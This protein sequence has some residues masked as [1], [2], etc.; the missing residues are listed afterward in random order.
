MAY[1]KQITPFFQL[2]DKRLNRKIEKSSAKQS[3]LGNFSRALLG[4]PRRRKQYLVVAVDVLLCGISAFLAFFI[5]LEIDSIYHTAV[6]KVFAISAVG[7]IPILW[8]MGQYQTAFR[9]GGLSDNKLILRAAVTYGVYFVLAIAILGLENVP[10]SVGIIQPTILFI[11]VFSIR[12]L[13]REFMENVN[14]RFAKNPKS[15]RILIYGAGITGRQLAVVSMRS[16]DWKFCGFL[17]DDRTLWGATIDGQ[18]VYNPIDCHKV[19]EK[20]SVDEIWIA[21]PNLSADRRRVI[22]EKL[23]P[24]TAHVKTLPSFFDI[25]SRKNVLSEV[26]ELNFNDFLGRETVTPNMNLI[27]NGIKDRTILVTGAG[28]SIGAELCRL[29]LDSNP[30]RLIILDQS[31]YALYLIHRELVDNLA[32]DASRIDTAE[33]NPKQI[34]G[35][36]P[37]IVPILA[38]CTNESLLEAI[39][40]RWMPET[41]FHAAAFKHVPLVESNIVS[42]VF[43]NVIGTYVCAKLAT[44]YDARTFILIST[45]KAVRPTN[46]MGV[47]KRLSE[48]VIKYFS[49]TSTRQHCLFSAVRFGN[50]LG[51][52]GSVIP[53]FQK[54]IDDGGPVTITHSE[55]TRYFMTIREAAELVLQAAGIAKGGEI[56][57]LD[58]GDPIKVLDLAK[59]MIELNGYT[60]RDSANPRGQIGIVFSGLRPGKSFTKSFSCQEL[61]KKPATLK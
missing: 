40:Q 46:V 42:A 49:S 5:R 29:I 12:W 15:R 18:R 36:F 60:I 59:A 10:M 4:L 30:K 24:L 25:A 55:V 51:S 9:Y 3:S 17:D 38:T 52:S 31:E 37:E 8:A 47:T 61:Q 26:R 32:R 22:I 34:G 28:G 39:F 13:F 41:I 45:D 58:M 19:I 33:A 48:I 20:H 35:S 7:A 2:K 14:D 54:Q 50:V 6:I 57:V 21:L 53:L 43:N 56:F 23:R 44:K 16:D 27:R 1:L 11:F